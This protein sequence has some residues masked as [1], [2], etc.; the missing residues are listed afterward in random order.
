[1]QK[2]KIL[3]KGHFWLLEFLFAKNCV[4]I[5]S[6]LLG[7]QYPLLRSFFSDSPKLR[8]NTY[9]LGSTVHSLFKNSLIIHKPIDLSNGR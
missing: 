1:M 4:V 6:F 9:V 5:L 3:A 2:K 8:T 7:F